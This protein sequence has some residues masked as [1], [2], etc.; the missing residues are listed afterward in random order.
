MKDHQIAKLIF[1]VGFP[2]SGTTW[3]SNV[4]NAHPDVLYRHEAIGRHYMSFGADLFHRLQFDYGLADGDYNKVIKTLLKAVPETD[5][6]PFFRKR[7]RPLVP[8]AAQHALWLAAKA[9]PV[10]APLYSSLFTPRRVTQIRLVLKET[11]TSSRLD[12]V[13]AGVRSDALLILI[14]HPYRVI[15]SHLD[16]FR[17]GLMRMH[18]SRTRSAWYRDHRDHSY[19]KSIGLTEQDILATSEV[20]YRAISWRVSNDSYLA[21]HRSHA[22]SRIVIYEQLLNNPSASVADIIQ[23]LSLGP[24]K[25]VE[26]FVR[27]STSSSGGDIRIMPDASSDYFSVFRGKSFDRN[28]WKRLLSGPELRVIDSHTDQLVKQL[29][30]DTWCSVATN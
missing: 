26:E 14:R 13:V 24:H 6:P 21:M 8:P 10:F 9:S 28:A 1:V 30:L 29:G 22:R 4:I 15:A 3:F 20:E 23:F 5:K 7:F 2:R 18:D 11:Q 17:R 27:N 25:Q 16:G 19:V 12:S